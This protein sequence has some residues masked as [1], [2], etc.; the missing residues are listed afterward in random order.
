MDIWVY[1]FQVMPPK[2]ETN[3]LSPSIDEVKNAY[4]FSYTLSRRGAYERG[5]TYPNRMHTN[6]LQFVL[7]NLNSSN[8]LL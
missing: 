7:V 3:H 8:I 5:K 2:R 6:V 1:S 4:S